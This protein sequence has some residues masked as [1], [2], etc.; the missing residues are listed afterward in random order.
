MPKW[1]KTPT[2]YVF[3]VS[4]WSVYLVCWLF[5]LVAALPLLCLSGIVGARLHDQIAHGP[6]RPDLSTRPGQLTRQQPAT[7]P[8]AVSA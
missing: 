7:R 8:G 2:A 5:V 3:E 1:L 6:D 4:F